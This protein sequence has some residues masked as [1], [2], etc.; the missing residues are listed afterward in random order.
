MDLDSSGDMES[1][2][3]VLLCLIL[4]ALGVATAIVLLLTGDANASATVDKN[5]QMPP[6][7]A[8]LA[9][10]LRRRIISL[11]SFYAVWCSHLV[12]WNLGV[13]ECC[14]EVVDR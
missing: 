8:I 11:F 5:R 12:M 4:P 6:P 13:S 7:I 14:H 2:R 1:S 3:L 9:V 10:T